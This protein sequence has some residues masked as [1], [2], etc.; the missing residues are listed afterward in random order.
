MDM[1]R[2]AMSTLN[3]TGAYVWEGLQ[4]GKL[5]DEIIENL[6]RETGTNSGIVDRD[7]HAFLEEL[8]L[9]HLLPH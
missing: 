9:N 5:I 4:Q 6:A 1:G 3:S 7:V 8:K 2:D